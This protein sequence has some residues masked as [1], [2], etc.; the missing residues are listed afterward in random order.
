MTGNTVLAWIADINT[1][2]LELCTEVF[3]DT[4]KSF[5]GLP[6]LTPRHDSHRFSRMFWHYPPCLCKIEDGPSWSAFQEFPDAWGIALCL[7]RRSG[8]EN[9]AVSPNGRGDAYSYY[10]IRSAIRRGNAYTIRSTFQ[11]T[12]AITGD[13]DT[14]T[15]S[16]SRRSRS[17]HLAR[18]LPTP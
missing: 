14:S 2:W 8:T 7:T 13:F 12:E 6:S 5:Q 9:R 16:S 11:I 4:V 3:P 18:W 1:W 10:S 15:S 17:L